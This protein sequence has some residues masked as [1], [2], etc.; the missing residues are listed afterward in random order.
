[1][2]IELTG[3]LHWNAFEGGFWSLDGDDDGDAAAT[4]FVL[5]GFTPPE[6][7]VDGARVHASVEPRPEQLGFQMAGTHADVVSM[8]ALD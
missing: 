2:A 3:T 5:A 6:G 1:M 4:T 7:L 8:R